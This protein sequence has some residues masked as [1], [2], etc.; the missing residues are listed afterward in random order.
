MVKILGRRE[1]IAYAF[2]FTM[3]FIA[4]YSVVTGKLNDAILTGFIAMCNAIIGFYFGRR[5]GEESGQ[6]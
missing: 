1:L 6:Q 2:S 3:C 4:I 5:A